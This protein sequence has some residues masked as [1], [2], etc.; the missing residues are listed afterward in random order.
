MYSF[1]KKYQWDILI[2]IFFL[3][4][5]FAVYLPI[6]R[7]GFLSDDYHSL[8]VTTHQSSV[9]HYFLTNIIGTRVGSAYGPIFNLFFN[10]LKVMVL[11]LCFKTRRVKAPLHV[12]IVV[13][14]LSPELS[15][16]MTTLSKSAL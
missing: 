11:Y 6:V 1:I 3:V 10:P 5:T 2:G 12:L 4:A 8:W 15:F 13:L 9:W 7:V 16:S 14:E